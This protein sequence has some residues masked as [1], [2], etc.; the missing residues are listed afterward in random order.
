MTS[1]CCLNYQQSVSPTP[2]IWYTNQNS[3]FVQVPSNIVSPNFCYSFF[4][5]SSSLNVCPVSQMTDCQTACRVSPLFF[6]EGCGIAEVYTAHV[7][8]HGI[9]G[10]L[11]HPTACFMRCNIE[12]AQGMSARMIEPMCGSRHL[13]CQVLPLY[14]GASQCSSPI[15]M[16]SPHRQSYSGSSIGNFLTPSNHFDMGFESRRN[17]QKCHSVNEIVAGESDSFYPKDKDVSESSVSSFDTNRKNRSACSEGHRLKVSSTSFHRPKQDYEISSRGQ[18][19]PLVNHNTTSFRK[20]KTDKFRELRLTFES[21]EMPERDIDWISSF[22]CGIDSDVKVNRMCWEGTYTI[23]LK[24]T[25]TAREALK[26]GKQNGLAISMRFPP[27]PRPGRP[28]EY[29]ALVDLRIS[30][31]KSLQDFVGFLRKGQIV[32]VDQAKKKRVRLIR[33]KMKVKTWG[34]V[35]MFSEKGKPQLA[36]VSGTAI[37]EL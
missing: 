10:D 13:G 22:F 18:N 33:P 27:K 31:G 12:S 2:T 21:D 4:N 35:S 29:I 9:T 36:L 5:P 37:C 20:N 28:L 16:D 7:F 17:F 6:E 26:F 11:Q 23:T 14:P 8:H 30:K 24:D 32:M 25:K 15:L 34:W 19:G 3:M 1:I